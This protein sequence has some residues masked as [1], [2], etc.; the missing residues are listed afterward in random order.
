MKCISWEPFQLKR[1]HR[2]I[3][4]QLHSTWNSYN[5]LVFNWNWSSDATCVCR[6][7]HFEYGL[8]VAVIIPPPF[9]MNCIKL[10]KTEIVQCGVVPIGLITIAISLAGFIVYASDFN[11]YDASGSNY[12]FGVYTGSTPPVLSS[13]Q[14][15]THRRL[16]VHGRYVHRK[17]SRLTP[18][19]QSLDYTSRSY[20]YIYP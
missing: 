9:I 5:A 7:Y 20:K 13:I 4:N 15:L 18:C 16:V 19:A 3:D 6:T 12:R 1:D 2:S 8:P 17:R 14:L 11:I 10:H